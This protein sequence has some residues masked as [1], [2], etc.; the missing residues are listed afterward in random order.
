MGTGE[1]RLGRWCSACRSLGNLFFPC[2]VW[3]KAISLISVST[4]Q[5]HPNLKSCL[6]LAP[7]LPPGKRWVPTFQQVHK[8]EFEGDAVL[9]GKDVDGAAG[10]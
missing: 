8:L 5:K 6:L 7:S 1:G 3:K 9:L 2:G 10:R 4:F